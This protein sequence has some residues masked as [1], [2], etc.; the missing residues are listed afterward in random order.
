MEKKT[1]TTIIYAV[2]WVFTIAAAIT[3]A[4]VTIYNM[5]HTVSAAKWL[6]FWKHYLVIL[7]FVG[8]PLVGLFVIGGFVDLMKLFKQLKEER[9]DENDDGFVASH[10]K[11]ETD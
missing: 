7:F 5:T 6:S 9:V 10:E 2:L 11:P 1:S 8:L 4:T 3:I